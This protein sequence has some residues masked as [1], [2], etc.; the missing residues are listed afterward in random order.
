M[1]F[2]PE[3]NWQFI[4]WQARD[5]ESG[6]VLENAVWFENPEKTETKAYILQPNSNIQIYAKCIQLPAVV[7]VEPSKASYA[8]TPITIKFNIPVEAEETT[9]SESLFTF[10][11]NNIE[12]SYNGENINYLFEAPFFNEDKTELTIIPKST[13]NKGILLKDYIENEIRVGSIEVKIV[14][15]E[16]VTVT[17]DDINLTINNSEQSVY[18]VPDVDVLAPSGS[19]IVSRDSSLSFENAANFTGNIF[20]QYEIATQPD[21]VNNDVYKNQVINNLSNG[22]IYIYGSYYDDGS[23]VNSVIVKELLTHT[24]KIN[25][26]TVESVTNSNLVETEY[27]KD[28][29]DNV[30]F[31]TIN[32]QTY[33]LIKHTITTHGQKNGAK[34]NYEGAVSLDIIVNDRCYNQAT[35][36]HYT[37]IRNDMLNLNDTYSSFI[38][39]T[40]Y[41]DTI[42]SI[43]SCDAEEDL[44]NSTY[45]KWFDY[46]AYL[47]SYLN[48]IKSIFC[49]CDLQMRMYNNVYYDL[50]DKNTFNISVEYTLNNKSIKSV[51][52]TAIQVNSPKKYKLTWDMS[53]FVLC[54][55][56]SIELVF[57]DLI[58]G[59][60][61]KQI[62][63]EFPSD[64]TQ[65]YT[66]ITE[67]GYYPY[68]TEKK[69]HIYYYDD[70][71]R[72]SSFD[73]HF[74]TLYKDKFVL[75]RQRI[76][77][78]NQ[79]GQPYSEDELRMQC[80]QDDDN[81]EIY[82]EPGFRYGIMIDGIVMKS[83]S[84][85]LLRE[86][87]EITDY[88]E[89]YKDGFLNEIPEIHIQPITENDIVPVVDEGIFVNIK[90]ND[91]NNDGIPDF[92][93]DYI[94][95]NEELLSEDITTL[96]SVLIAD[97]NSF[98]R[99]DDDRKFTF[100]GV[101]NGVKSGE[102]YRIAP[103][104]TITTQE[105]KEKFDFERPSFSYIL[106]GNEI[107]IVLKDT[108]GLKNGSIT[109]HGETYP[110][111]ISEDSI[112]KE[113]SRK[114]PLW[115]ILDSTEDSSIVILS[116]EDR[117]GNKLQQTK[118]MREFYTI[119]KQSV[120]EKDANNTNK[121]YL[122]KNSNN[123]CFFYGF[124]AKGFPVELNTN[125]EMLVY[126]ETAGIS[127]ASIKSKY[128]FAENTYLKVF[129]TDKNS[130]Q[131]SSNKTNIKCSNPV[132]Y[133]LGTPGN[134]KNDLMI[135]N[136]NSKESMVI[137][138][139]KK[140]FLF[141][142]LQLRN[143]IQNV[144]IGI[145]W[146]GNILKNLNV[147]KKFLIAQHHH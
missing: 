41:S 20:H 21:G 87:L 34:D 68:S 140:K 11:N 61:Q 48:Y 7:S 99:Y 47:Q 42:M 57:T 102:T 126:N 119:S 120:V 117:A 50:L 90:F 123:V 146:N 4:C 127:D 104:I 92:N 49:Y 75:I 82:L 19:L 135:P 24:N 63:C 134:K 114:I 137:G 10:D 95:C 121:M 83:V 76:E 13:Q 124:G 52:V 84:V 86:D 125:D 118:T 26:E 31:R 53:D 145:V 108:V 60:V 85:P 8:N 12:L 97:I 91:E 138:S 101:K 59:N 6:D 39:K 93:Y 18:Y 147:V 110:I 35:A 116:A 65:Y 17:N 32:N 98:N 2:T 66:A 14:F 56:S 5:K 96:Y 128:S 72:I 81:R 28:S 109:V 143:H 112:V 30:T 23:G 36:E 89:M 139:D 22:T 133:Y 141:I 33:F 105:Q 1:Q 74:K 144:K 67:E 132:Y 94:V 80:I 115:K 142:Q 51:P 25:N 103:Q 130:S 9:A 129:Y 100:Y 54:P 70:D 64:N 45:C 69:L 88:T 40:N 131:Y 15:S 62:L 46:E 106:K 107:E 78:V 44:F 58:S 73:T 29:G 136:G 77:T 111:T 38:P 43:L 79:F 122:T 16:A 37:V 55:D 3:E 27:T 71:P 113:A